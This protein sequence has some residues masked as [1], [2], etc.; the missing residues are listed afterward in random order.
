MN[1]QLAHLPTCTQLIG[2]LI[3][4]MTHYTSE[5]PNFEVDAGIKKFFENFYIIS[6]TPDAHETYAEQFTKD[7]TLILAS[8]EVKGRDGPCVLMKYR[9]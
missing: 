1:K 3:A 6:D 4:K 5:Y 9:L 2:D 8:K 7:G